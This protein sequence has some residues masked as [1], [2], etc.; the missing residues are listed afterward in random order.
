VRRIDQAELLEVGHDVAHR[1]RRQR[2]GDQSRQVARTERLAGG[3]IALDDL[4]ENLARTLVELRQ[5]D[6]RTADGHV[7]RQLN[8]LLRNLELSIPAQDFKPVSLFA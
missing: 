2:R 4:T 5:A 6:L 1:G 7:L 8:P 3:E